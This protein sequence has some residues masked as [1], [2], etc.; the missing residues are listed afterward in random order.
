VRLRLVLPR[1]GR[2]RGFGGLA[3]AAA[4]ALLAAGCGGSNEPSTITAASVPTPTL[5]TPAAP[6]KP[7]APAPPRLGIGLTEFNANLLQHG[8]VPAAFAPWRDKVEALRP[9]WFRLVVRWDQAMPT[10]SSPPSF[11]HPE[12]G[13]VRGLP[14]CAPFDG[15]RGLLRA[16]ASQQRANPG[17]WRL[18]VVFTY[19]PPWAATGAHGCEQPHTDPRARAVDTEALPGYRNLIRSF[20]AEARRDGA[21]VGALSPWNE[22]NHPSFISPQ[23]ATCDAHAKLLSPAVYAQLAGAARD[24]LKGSDIRL[25]LGE[26]AGKVAP[27]PLAG[28]VAEFVKALP[29]DVACSG[30]IW[31][32]HMYTDLPNYNLA[33]AVGQM[34]Q[35]LDQ[36]ACTKGKPVWVTETGV[37]ADHA[38]RKRAP[39]EAQL[40]QD[41]HAQ[42]TSL[43]RWSRDPRVQNVFQYEFRDAPDFP[44]GL[45][46]SGLT[47]TYPVYDVYRRAS[48]NGTYSC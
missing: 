31:S 23:R 15:V 6:A 44:V 47:R 14:P 42:A 8:E 34:E 13:C 10:P 1:S 4:S 26:L 41:C 43:A 24:E 48:R 20:L 37:G 29:D 3:L 12:D 2:R 16:V 5:A 33:G 40:R 9:R 38:G 30:A 17:D 19:A 21:K 28:G 35:A 11:A 27:S 46:D 32:Q 36:R 7:A 39:G 18:L 25:V 22:P 45:A